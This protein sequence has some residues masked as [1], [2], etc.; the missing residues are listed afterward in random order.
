MQRVYELQNIIYRTR[1]ADDTTK[2]SA[3]VAEI[4]RFIVECLQKFSQSPETQAKCYFWS[5]FGIFSI[6]LLMNAKKSE[7]EE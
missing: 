5:F 7:T 2:R 3:D 4:S 6:V 1:N